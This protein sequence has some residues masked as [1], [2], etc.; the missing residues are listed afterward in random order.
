MEGTAADLEIH[1]KEVL[2]VKKRMNE[3]LLKHTGQTL[4][5]ILLK[6]GDIVSDELLA[7]VPYK[8]WTEISV[9]DPLDGKLRDIL[10]NLEETTEAVKLAFGE[11]IGPQTMMGGFIVLFA[12]I[13]HIV[14]SQRRQRLVASH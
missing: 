10:R 4:D 11:K 2:R 7:T 9:G 12:V 1:A 13:L 6:K 14:L 5:K 3:I 8:Y